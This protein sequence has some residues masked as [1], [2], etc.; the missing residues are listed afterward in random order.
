VI[1]GEIVKIYL[2]KNIGFCYGVQ[3]ALEMASEAVGEYP[4]LEIFTLGEIIHN[5]FVIRRLAEQGVH[6]IEDF[7]EIDPSV[8]MI[9]SHGAS[10]KVFEDLKAAGH[11]IL[12]ATC[13]KVRRIQKKAEELSMEGRPMILYGE[14]EHPEVQGILGWY[15]G[16][17][18]VVKSE[19]S[20]KEL[21]V[22][23]NACILA[24]TTSSQ[25]EFDHMLPLILEHAPNAEVFP[26]ICNATDVRQNE[27]IEMAS[28]CDAMIVI[29]GRNSSN[30]ARL[31]ETCR[32]Y[33]HQTYFIQ[34]VAEL[35]LNELR[36][37]HKIGIISGTSTPDWI[38]KEVYTRMSDIQNPEILNP[39]VEE[40][41]TVAP[42][43]S[44]EEREADFATAFEKTMVQIRPGQIIKGKIVSFNDTEVC[45][46][47]GYKSD[48][49]IH[50]S[51]FE[52]AEGQ[53][54]AD[55]LHEGDEIE[56]EVVK[57]NDGE[58]NVLLSKKNIEIRRNWDELVKAQEEDARFEATGKQVVKGGLIAM[59][60]GIRAFIPAS[61]LDTRYVD[62]IEK[63]VGQTFP[64]KILEVDVNRRRIVASRK[65]AVQEEAAAAKKAKW[66]LL[67]EGDTVKGIVRRLTDFGAFV[68]I[69]GIDGLVHVTNLAWGNVKHPKDVVT[70]GQ[71]VNCLI[72]K[73]DR[74]NQRVSLGMKQ[75]LPKPWDVADEK[76]IPGSIVTGKVVRIVT[77]G[78]FVEL[79]PGLDGLVHISQISDTRI[80]K[81]ESV[82]E[83]GQIVNVK[84][85]DVNTQEHRI[86]LSIRDANIPVTENDYSTDNFEEEFD[87]EDNDDLYENDDIIETTEA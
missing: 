81:V 7:T 9:R 4:D 29:G 13:P 28:E 82:L 38:I 10:K 55:V 76:Y 54:A 63:F 25:K 85:L 6:A 57:V 18:Y 79:E 87:G 47:I 24:Q 35:P 86:S 27:A 58:G 22:L 40:S 72:L 66:D 48:G 50:L 42:A 75:L 46:N 68:D 56:V 26:S 51:E 20:V 14:A 84:I 11:T 32:Q 59:V 78:A 1:L 65:V 62:K 69:G 49:F 31:A 70:P 64:V 80:D 33:C 53:T 71:E 37:V 2:A 74:E 45:V 21:P 44:E 52:L 39:E 83:V 30:S 3:R 73:V 16:K 15:C 36:S 61:Q 60:K 43:E 41:T 23:E 77:F 5:P 12:D 19:E 34:D 17:A 8:V 67:K